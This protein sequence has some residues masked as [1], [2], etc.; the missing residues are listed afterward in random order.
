M[1]SSPLTLESL[2]ADLAARRTTSRALVDAC[3]ARIDEPGGQGTVAFLHIDRDAAR[4]AADAMDA[5]REAN[6]E[7]SRFAGIPIAIK[8]LFDVQRQVTRAGST[9][10]DGAP[11]AADAPAVERLRRAGFILIG[12]TNMSEFAFSG[13]GLN[14]HFGTPLSPWNRHEGRIAGGSTSGGAVAVADLMAHGAL[15]TDTGGSCRIPAAFCGL[16]GFK[17]TA[18]RI[19]RAGAVP[20]STTLDSVGSIAR[21]VTCCETIDA[22][23]AGQ[24][25]PAAAVVTVTGLRFAAPQNYVLDSVDAAVAAA[26]GAAIAALE[27]AG[28]V[29]DAVTIPEL[30]GIPTINAKGGFAAAES[31][32][33]HRTL[34]ETRSGLY[35]PRVIVR[36]RRGAEQSAA[37]LLDLLQARAALIDGVMKRLA[38]YDAM[39]LPTTP[40]VPPRLDACGDDAEYGR[41]NLLAL[42]NPTVIN[43]IDGCAVSLPVHERGG[44]PIGLMLAACHDQDMRLLR[45]AR[46]VERLLD[47]DRS[48]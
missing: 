39:L 14:P 35:D 38:G 21:S 28:A 32:A 46:A 6:A 19:P 22:I 33:W 23:L 16:V 40:T 29:V 2:A 10:L 34:M 8:D 7:P 13:L 11:A 42:R 48:S 3:L 18:S 27:R 9:A 30:D 37:D 15:G 25:E 43:M 4:R 31:Y 36:I 17:P 12:R 47:R 24:S 41:L 44:P 26:L 20:L 1:P 45:I 5:L